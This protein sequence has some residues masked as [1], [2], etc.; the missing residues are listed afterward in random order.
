MCRVC[1]AVRAHSGCSLSSVP[2]ASS[3]PCSELGVDTLANDLFSKSDPHSLTQRQPL[4]VNHLLPH[5][6]RLSYN[7]QPTDLS[8]QTAAIFCPYSVPTPPR[9][10]FGWG[11]SDL[12]QQGLPQPR[13]TLQTYVCST[14]SLVAGWGWS[15]GMGEPLGWSPGTQPC[16]TWEQ[17]T[18]RGRGEDKGIPAERDPSTAFQSGWQLALIQV[19]WQDLLRSQGQAGSGAVASLF[20]NRCATHLA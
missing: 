3:S 16:G 15:R 10:L 7:L 9:Q 2:G 13:A 20:L 5:P 4:G 19:R 8:S 14:S 11:R 6:R 12:T 1:R 18:V 17:G